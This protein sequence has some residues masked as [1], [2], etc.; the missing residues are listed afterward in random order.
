FKINLYSC[1][2]IGMPNVKIIKN[3]I[4]AKK[5]NN[6]IWSDV[7]IS[8]YNI[9]IPKNG[10]YVAFI[11]LDKKEYNTEFVESDFGTIQA[12]PS[13]KLKRTRDIKK[14]SYV[15]TVVYNG[16]EM[17]RKFNWKKMIAR[18]EIEIEFE[19]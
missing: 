15:G 8:K 5:D 12:V 2:S 13:L 16:D 17:E 7:D 11:V 3:D 1:D 10:I 9:K 18:F 14:K 6:K 4:F 19:K